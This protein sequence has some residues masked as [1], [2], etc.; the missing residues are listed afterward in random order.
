MSPSCKTCQIIQDIYDRNGGTRASAKLVGYS[1]ELLS[2]WTLLGRVP[3]RKVAEV[4]HKLKCNPYLLN[5]KE[6]KALV[7]VASKW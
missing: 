6:V 5:N 7:E 3:L 2:K 1:Y 4:A